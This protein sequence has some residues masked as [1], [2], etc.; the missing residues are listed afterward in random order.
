MSF[1]EGYRAG[2]KVAETVYRESPGFN[3]ADDAGL[4]ETLKTQGV[5]RKD[6]DKLATPSLKSTGLGY[7][8][9][10]IVFHATHGKIW[11]FD[12]QRKIER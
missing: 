11:N 2:K 9:A 5:E 6:I 1:K 10:G 8:A 12:G 4:A 3:S 7:V